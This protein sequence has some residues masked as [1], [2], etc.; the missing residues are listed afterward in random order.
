MQTVTHS[1]LK[2]FLFFFRFFFILFLFNIFLQFKTSFFVFISFSLFYFCKWR[3]YHNIPQL[4]YLV[5]KKKK[6]LKMENEKALEQLHLVKKLFL[7]QQFIKSWKI[8]L[9]LVQR[10]IPH[11]PHIPHPYI[12]INEMS[13]VP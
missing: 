13:N 9:L 12:A 11:I 5:Q 4:Y 2:C 6:E 8:H 7:L 10:V 1:E 3:I